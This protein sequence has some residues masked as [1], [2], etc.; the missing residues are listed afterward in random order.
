MEGVYRMYGR[1]VFRF[2]K[3]TA[4][5]PQNDGL[6]K[7]VT[8]FKKSAIFGV[9]ILDLWG[10][11]LFFGPKKMR[12]VLRSQGSFGFEKTSG[13]LSLAGDCWRGVRKRGNNLRVSCKKNVPSLKQT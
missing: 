3:L 1:G 8:P 4:G 5:G 12:P 2:R 13:F 11:F 7:K 10:V 6:W 9:S